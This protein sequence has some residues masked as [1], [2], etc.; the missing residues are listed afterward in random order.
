MG[1][2]S[3][4]VVRDSNQRQINRRIYQEI[5]RIIGQEVDITSTAVGAD[6]EFSVS[7]GLGRV[8]AQ[9]QILVKEGHD[10]A[11][12]PGLANYYTWTATKRMPL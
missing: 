12:Q 11:L 7:H 6:T 1:L 3:P 2:D 5:L 4:R 9:V 8:P 10:L